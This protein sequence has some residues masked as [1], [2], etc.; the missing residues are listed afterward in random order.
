MKY[1][2]VLT[3]LL[4]DLNYIFLN[5]FHMFAHQLLRLVPV[6]GNNGFHQS[7]VLVIHL[8]SGIMFLHNISSG[9]GYDL[10]CQLRCRIQDI[11]DQR[12]PCDPADLR[13]KL[14]IK[15]CT[16]FLILCAL[17]LCQ[18]GTQI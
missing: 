5:G 10:L 11:V 17:Q 2:A 13:M 18:N 4:C 1:K 14:L 7:S 3:L 9:T 6:S 15:T 16:S 12:I 8:K